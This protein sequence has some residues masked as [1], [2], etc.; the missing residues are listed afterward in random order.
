MKRQTVILVG[1]A[2]D[3]ALPVG[4]G[5]KESA[6]PLP[7][8]FTTYANRSPM[9]NLVHVFSPDTTRAMERLR[10]APATSAQGQYRR[11][12]VL[13]PVAEVERIRRLCRPDE[14]MSDM[15]RRVLLEVAK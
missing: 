1:R 6:A 2:H 15:V 10:T 11:L 8:S 14:Q 13:L 7:R 9:T 5:T 12:T 4:L 3:L